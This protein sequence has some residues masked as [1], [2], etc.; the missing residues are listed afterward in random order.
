MTARSR[1]SR[2]NPAMVY[3][4][5]QTLV[6]GL[7]WGSIFSIALATYRSPLRAVK[8]LG[9]LKRFWTAYLDRHREVKYARVAGRYYWGQNAPGWPS[10]TFVTFMR[11]ELHRVLPQEGRTRSL[12]TMVWA[13]TGKCPLRCQHCFEWDTLNQP[14]TLSRHDLMQIAARFQERGITQ[15]QLSGG[16]PLAR[17]DDV[18]AII[19]SA[20]PGTDFMLL[21]S[22]YQLTRENAERLKQ[23]G[24]TSVNISLDHWQPE[25]HNAFRGFPAAYQW[26]EKA[27]KNAREAGL[28]VCL[29]LCATTDFVTRDNLRAYARLAR[30]WGVGFIQVLEPRA[31]GRF[32]GREVALSPGQEALLEDFLLALNHDPAYRDF[33]LVTYHGYHQRRMGCFGAGD[34][35]LYVDTFGNVHACPFCR[36]PNGNCLLE[37]LVDLVSRLQQT[38]CHQFASAA[39]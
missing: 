17:L 23:A 3:G 2:I 14:E 34:R 4:L 20:E 11:N 9:A 32:N 27:A 10:R 7:I 21:T 22:G 8:A 18:V 12:Q 5:H 33:P 1:S 28:L 37:P 35:Y 19:T 24:L 38:G 31:V 13:I 29:S 39:E 6:K 30:Q 26:A 15:I 16:E 36:K 25:A